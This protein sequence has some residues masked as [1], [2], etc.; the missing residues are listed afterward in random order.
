V[1]T[2]IAAMQAG[3]PIARIE[4]LD[5]LQ[6]KASIAYSKLEGFEE[7]PTLFLEFHG[8]KVSVDDQIEQFK[9]I[10][11]EFH[12]GAFQWAEN[13]EDRNHLW[14]ARHDAYYAGL[15]LSPGKQAFATDAC[16]PISHLADCIMEAQTEAEACGLL[17]PIVGHVGDGN[18]HA[19]LLFNPA[20]PSE[21]DRVDALAQR[22]AVCALR[23]GGTCTGEHGVGTHKLGLMRS[24]HGDAVDLMI[25]IKKAFDPN[26]IMNPGKTVPFI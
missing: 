18:F 10:I 3:L 22:I 7:K 5:A 2:A 20:N 11:D 17:C 26:N 16:V 25:V 24:E 8:T 12:G 1:N 15:S 21:R 13:I 23:H 4:L 9:A 14:K 6:M 19:L